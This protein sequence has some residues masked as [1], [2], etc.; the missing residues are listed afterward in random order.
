MLGS[1]AAGYEGLEFDVVLTADLV[2]VLSHEPLLNPHTCVTADGEPVSEGLLIQD[3]TLTEL[4]EQFLCGARPSPDFPD[5]PVVPETHMTWSELLLALSDPSAEG[6]EVHVDVKFEPGQTPVAQDF[7]EAILDSWWITDLANPMFVS[8][9]LVEALDAFEAHALSRGEALRTSLIWPRFT[10]E[11]SSTITG[12]QHEALKTLGLE[13]L[14]GL[15]RD[16][17][18]EGIAVPY[19]L[20]DRSSAWEAW[21][22]GLD[23]RVWTVNDPEL[24]QEF[25]DWPIG[26]VITDRP[27][28]APCG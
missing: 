26:G 27:E 28:E 8:A 5:V 19:Q 3:F 6:M 21:E 2:P 4:H 10:P 13:S 25:C 20:I 15:A 22:A 7:A 23:V 14:V 11:T 18:V 1:I 9:N 24:L 16:A 12:L 17:G